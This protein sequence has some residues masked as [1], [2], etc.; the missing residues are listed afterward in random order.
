MCALLPPVSASRGRALEGKQP[1]GSEGA[2]AESTGAPQAPAYVVTAERRPG[3][4]RPPGDTHGC[5]K[6]S[7]LQPSETG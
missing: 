4:A 1:P 2:G 7:S 3:Q 5:R 6:R